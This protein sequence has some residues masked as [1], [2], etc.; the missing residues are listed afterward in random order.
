MKTLRNLQKR[1]GVY[2]IRATVRG[3]R[4]YQSLDTGDQA[5]AKARARIILDHAQ[6]QRWEDVEALKSRRPMAT[7][8][9]VCAVYLDLAARHR[10]ETGKPR[11]STAAGYVAQLQKLVAFVHDGKA[12]DHP[13]SVLTRALLKDYT[14]RFV[15]SYPEDAAAR[16]RA[17]RTAAGT[18]RNAR[19]V[20][21]RWALRDMEDRLELPNLSEFLKCETVRAQKNKY[22]F[23]PRDLVDA[24]LAGARALEAD[25]PALFGVF[26]L[27]YYLGMRAKEAAGATW[28]WIREDGDKRLMQIMRRADF[29]PK[30]RDRAVPMGRQVYERL[31][32]LRRDG[33]EFM[34]PGG[35]PRARR[36]LV[37][38][39]FAAWMRSIGWT[40]AEYPKAAHELRKLI[41]SEWY[42][43]YGVEVAADW[44]GDTLQVTWDYYADLKRHP[45]PVDIEG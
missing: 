13:V 27:C 30:S 33:D 39:Q 35:S 5:V 19:A 26:L 42:T 45:D 29:E 41:G 10:A 21:A 24:T 38:R 14:Q 4:I 32:A 43:R 17:R 23:P 16:E 40:R 3:C 25:S 20:F 8:G 18:I 37:T 2:Y 34:L 15:E 12:K 44:L 6:G 31:V 11:A 1:H 9:D 36:D 28:G 7:I 22:R